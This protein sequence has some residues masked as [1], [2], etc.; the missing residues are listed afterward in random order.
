MTGD[1]ARIIYN[2]LLRGWYVVRGPA[3]TPISGRFD[4]EF[5]AGVWLAK[6][7]DR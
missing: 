6:R 2:V 3:D 4:S 1:G 7:R 5:D